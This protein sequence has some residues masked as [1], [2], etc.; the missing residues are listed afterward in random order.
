MAASLG[1]LA[2]GAAASILLSGAL[3]L[4]LAVTASLCVTA[5]LFVLPGL[6]VYR[7]SGSVAALVFSFVGIAFGVL[8]LLALFGVLGSD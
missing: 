4:P 3:A 5:Q 6:A 7:S 8:S 2:L 1:I